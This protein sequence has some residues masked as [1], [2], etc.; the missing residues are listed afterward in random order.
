MMLFNYCFQHEN[1]EIETRKLEN[2][3]RTKSQPHLFFMPKIM[4]AETEKKLKDSEK[5]VNR[6][7][8]FVVVL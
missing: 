4:T 6:K 1:W 8:I 5:A 2:F 3:I 7:F